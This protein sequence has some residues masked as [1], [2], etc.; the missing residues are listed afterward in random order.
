MTPAAR[1]ALDGL[2]VG[3]VALILYLTTKAVVRA[4]I[5]AVLRIHGA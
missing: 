4:G 3:S 5:N 1:K 2:T